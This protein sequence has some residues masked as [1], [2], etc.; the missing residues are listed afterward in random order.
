M[1]KAEILSRIMKAESDA[2]ATLKKANEKAQD[3]V[4]K[5]RAASSKT[6]TVARESGQEEALAVVAG[7]RAEAT[8]KADKV[9]SAGDEEISA[10]KD[11]SETR[12]SKAV[13]VVLKSFLAE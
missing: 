1:S 2:E 8:K 5:A 10:I 4:S 11:N 12:R 3:I 7:A 6:I 13:E 9:S